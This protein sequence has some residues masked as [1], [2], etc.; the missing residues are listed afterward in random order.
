MCSI[1]TIEANDR[2]LVIFS[3]FYY[4]LICFVE[5]LIIVVA[6]EA[7]LVDEVGDGGFELFGFYSQQVG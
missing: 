7:V 1:A 4:L 5:L 3:S 6:V 2:P